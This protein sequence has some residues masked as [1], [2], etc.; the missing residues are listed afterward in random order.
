MSEQ[1]SPQKFEIEALLRSEALLARTQAIAHVGSWEL[2][3]AADRL[4]WSDEVY[5]IFGLE[6]QEFEATYNDFLE[7]I[8]PDDR[9]MV[10]AAYSGSL[11]SDQNGYEVEHR[12]VRKDSGDIRYVYEKCIHERNQ[13]GIIVRSVGIIQDITWRKQAEEALQERERYLS[14]I[15]ETTQD[16]FWV[17]SSQGRI[18]EVNQAY[19]NMSGYTKAELLQMS[20]PDLEADETPADIQHRIR[21]I[22]KHGSEVFETRHRRKDGSLFHVEVSAHWLDMHGGQFI[23]FCREISK[24]KQNEQ[25]LQQALHALQRTKND[26]QGIIQASSTILTVEA[27]PE[28]ARRLFDQASAHIGSSAG[29]V[30]LLSEDGEE[31]EL[32]FLESGGRSCAVDPQLPM[33]IRGLR[34]ESYRTNEVVLDNNFNHSQWMKYMPE[35]H[36]ELDNVMFAPIVLNGKT[37]GIIGLANK[38][39]GFTSYDAQ[40]AKIFGD[41]AAISLRNARSLEKMKELSRTDELTGCLNRRGLLQNLEYELKR[42]QRIDTSLTLIMFDIDHFKPINDMYGHDT[43][44]QILKKLVDITSKIL[45]EMDVLSRW[46]G[47]EFLILTPNTDLEDAKAL[48][49]RI[50]QTVAGFNFPR[51]GQITVSL[52]VIQY[53]PGDTRDSLINRADL[54]MYLAK[55]NGRNQV[56]AEK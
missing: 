11:Q 30:A 21:R 28:A 47:E 15:L 50:R 54:Y 4:T 8:H 17:L 12:I 35:G 40:L 49:E 48:A 56:L 46:G 44:D 14:L 33:P 18:T 38:T 39:G 5:R 2:D 20:I 23:C 26:L 25:N 51:V 32:L 41:L 43:G 27:F 9:L 22:V 55:K 52:G 3:L 53:Q 29:Y 42:L 31:N 34:A 19:C 6:P 36:I 7:I 37:L 45:R 10:D 1:N 16:G 24:R 13:A